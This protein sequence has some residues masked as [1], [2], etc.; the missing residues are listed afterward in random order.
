[1]K[2]V[3][4]AIFFIIGIAFITS[5]IYGQISQPEEQNNTNP[6][7]TV[8]PYLEGAAAGKADAK[9]NIVYGFGGFF[10]GVLGVLGAAISDPQPEPMKVNY[11]LQTKGS[12]YVTAYTTA[13]TKASHKLNLTYSAVGCGAR[14]L[15]SAALYVSIINTIASE[16]DDD[17]YKNQR[18]IIVSVPLKNPAHSY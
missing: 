17:Y 16:D 6:V 7:N 9:G 3:K 12:D 11:L 10:C 13:Y 2:S 4:L 14:I 5:D 15:I 8:N 1:M 18:K